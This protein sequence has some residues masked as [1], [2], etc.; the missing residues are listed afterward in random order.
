MF[1]A[2]IR[3]GGHMRIR[4]LVT[5]A[6]MTFIMTCTGSRVFAVV[7]NSDNLVHREYFS[8]NLFTYK[9][10]EQ[11]VYLGTYLGA[12]DSVE[13]V[14]AIL[15][16]LWMKD[17][18]VDLHG[19]SDAKEGETKLY[20]PE[21]QKYGSTWLSGMWATYAGDT[22]PIDAVKIDLLVV[23]AG[24]NFSLHLYDPGA[25]SG[26]WNTMYLPAG[27]KSFNPISLS[28]LS[29]YIYQKETIPVP[30]PST[31]LLLGIGLAGIAM[32]AARRRRR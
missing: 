5:I 21:V 30:E 1:R 29:A 18:I 23:K 22:L 11:G 15:E 32:C 17:V 7:F 16:H 2:K 12:N 9:G 28:H 26:V 14:K 8:E 6:L 10:P 25:S 19:K 31:F 3:N 27:G 13:L 24:N 4:T 20:I